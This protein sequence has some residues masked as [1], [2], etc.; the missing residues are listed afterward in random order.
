SGTRSLGGGYRGFTGRLALRGTQTAGAS[1]GKL[2]LH[3]LERRRLAC[4]QRERGSSLVEEHQLAVEGRGP[5][6]VRV[7]QQSGLGVDQVEYEQLVAQH[8]GRER[9]DIARQADGCRTEQNPCLGDIPF[10]DST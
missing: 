1:L 7:T 10:G 6:R 9:A 8:L 3:Q 4:P 5:C 2:R